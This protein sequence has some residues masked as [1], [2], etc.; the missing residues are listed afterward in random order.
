MSPPE[1]VVARYTE[2]LKSALVPA[3]PGDL[4][5][6]AMELLLQVCARTVTGVLVTSSAVN[7]SNEQLMGSASRYT[8][9]RS[10]ISLPLPQL[11]GALPEHLT[12]SFPWAE[13]FLTGSL[14]GLRAATATLVGLAARRG[15]QGGAWGVRVLELVSNKVCC[16]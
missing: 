7:W 14:P 3:A 6:H 9:C 8:R 1:D 16:L 15:R 10:P 2:L 13:V 5:L 12:L 4:H 11:Y